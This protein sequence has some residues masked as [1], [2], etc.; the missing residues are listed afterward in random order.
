M[1]RCQSHAKRTSHSYDVLGYRRPLPK[2]S[3]TGNGPNSR[4]T[5][6]VLESRQ[7]KLITVVFHHLSHKV[8]ALISIFMIDVR[9]YWN[10]EAKFVSGRKIG[11]CQFQLSTLVSNRKSWPIPSADCAILIT[12]LTLWTRLTSNGKKFD[13]VWPKSFAFVDNRKTPSS[14]TLL[15]IIIQSKLCFATRL[16]KSKSFISVLIDVTHLLKIVPQPVNNHKPLS[17]GQLFSII[18]ISAIKF[19]LISTMTLSTV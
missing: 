11:E 3:L 19:V 6:K 15:P 18:W 8:V 4:K 7:G 14:P 13:H 16:I 5:L 10:T 1:D 12:V 9:W 17:N 2:I